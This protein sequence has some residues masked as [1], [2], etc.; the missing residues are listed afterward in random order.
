MYPEEE[1]SNLEGRRVS[2][3]PALFPN[4]GY[5][6]S[7]NQSMAVVAPRNNGQNV[8]TMS[9]HT[10]AV[11]P[12]RGPCGTPAAAFGNG[13]QFMNEQ[14]PTSMVRFHDS[15]CTGVRHT[16]DPGADGVMVG[17]GSPWRGDA[18]ANNHVVWG[19]IEHPSEDS[20]MSRGTSIASTH[21]STHG[22]THASGSRRKIQNRKMPTPDDV[23]WLD[24]QGSRS[25]YSEAPDSP[26]CFGSSPLAKAMPN[27]LP[28]EKRA[29][30]QSYVFS[31]QAFEQDVEHVDP[32]RR[33]MADAEDSD[34]SQE[35][36]A[37][38]AQQLQQ[39]EQ[40]ARQQA[41]EAEGVDVQALLAQVPLGED[42]Q[43][44]SIGS[45]GHAN[46]SCQAACAF[47]Q[48][49]RG[50]ANGQMCDFCHFPHKVTRQRQRHKVRPRP[51]KGKRDK[52]RK[53]WEELKN[54]VEENPAEFDPEKVEL[55][56]SISTYDRLRAKLV[57]R[58]KTHK[59]NVLAE[60]VQETGLQ[61]T[62]DEFDG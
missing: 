43:S 50:C 60:R 32:P 13:G 59:T 35:G 18:T 58:L 52:Y 8:T 6:A 10:L 7:M 39:Q 11:H 24:S 48:R 3:D 62:P 22:S 53:H 44:T 34:S 1:G 25:S 57:T 14:A 30:R 41:R 40:Q 42:G 9:P 20:L 31:A 16:M 51:C 15:V 12:G 46:G 28:L 17:K 21:G 37:Q 55:P 54:Q 38:Q 29:I 4:A 56:A 49:K 19:R 27:S 36:M 26:S 47:A 33:H 2:L 23:L 45:I 5:G 61:D